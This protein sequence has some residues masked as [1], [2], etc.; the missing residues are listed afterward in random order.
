[1]ANLMWGRKCIGGTLLFLLSACAPNYP[2]LKPRFQWLES[3][4]AR[5]SASLIVLARATKVDQL[6]PTLVHGSIETRL[7]RVHTDVEYVVKGD[8]KGRNLVFYMYGYATPQNGSLERIGPGTHGF[9]FLSYEQGI[10]R[11]I[12]DL[13]ESHLDFDRPG[14]PSIARLAD[15]T[16]GS[17]ISLLA[18]GG[19]VSQETPNQFAKWLAHAVPMSLGTGGFR[20]T[21]RLVA[22]LLR[23]G[24]ER[25]R[26]AACIAAANYLFGDDKCLVEAASVDPYGAGLARK[27]RKS[28]IDELLSNTKNSQLKLLLHYDALG[29]DRGNPEDVRYFLE[30]VAS[31]LNPVIAS[32]GRRAVDELIRSQL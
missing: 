3:F 31:S 16:P 5:F 29:V 27:F 18:L 8:F 28:L 20:L 19:Q 1:M 24:D 23:S 13:W 14:V 25:I 7:W 22:P 12:V 32:S 30:K 9:Y 2:H 4:E 6:G 10:A 21:D 11:A 26:D 15:E 17:K